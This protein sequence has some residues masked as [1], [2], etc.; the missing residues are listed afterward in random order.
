MFNLNGMV[1]CGLLELEGLAMSRTQDFPSHLAKAFDEYGYIP[2]I[3]VFTGVVGVRG[4]S[5]T[6]DFSRLIAREHLGTVKSTRAW[7]PNS[8][9]TIRAYLWTLDREAVRKFLVKH[10]VAMTRVIQNYDPYGRAVGSERVA[11]SWDTN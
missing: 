8:G 7:N 10:K 1:C 3:V 5:Y 6:R 2:A 4:E 11:R 9:N